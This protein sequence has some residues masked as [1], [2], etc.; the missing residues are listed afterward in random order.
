VRQAAGRSQG[1]AIVMALLE[2]VAA[3]LK[4]TLS[5]REVVTVLA[6][7]GVVWFVSGLRLRGRMLTGWMLVPGLVAVACFCV[8]GQEHL[9]PNQSFEGPRLIRVG[10]KDSIMLSDLIG[11]AFAAVACLLALAL[12]WRHLSAVIRDA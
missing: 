7:V 5:V 2:R 4:S 11:V 10:Y 12:I 1:T 6:I 8:A 3:L 9:F